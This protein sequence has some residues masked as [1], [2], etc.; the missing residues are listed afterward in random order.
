MVAAGRTKLQGTNLTAGIPIDEF[1][2]TTAEREA[3]YAAAWGEGDQGEGA[4]GGPVAVPYD[5]DTYISGGE[6]ADAPYAESGAGG[7]GE[8][9]ADAYSH[10]PPPPDQDRSGTW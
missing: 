3:A 2:D 8:P 1:D 10:L 4:H 9:E 7:Y 6:S 5:D